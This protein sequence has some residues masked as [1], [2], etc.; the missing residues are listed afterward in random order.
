MVELYFMVLANTE[1]YLKHFFVILVVLSLFACPGCFSKNVKMGGKVTFSDDKSPLTV[2]TVVFE[3]DDYQARGAIKPDG[4]YTLGSLKETD[5]LPPG[6]YRV[7]IKG[8][9]I[10]DPTVDPN[11]RD[12][13]PAL[14]LLVAKFETGRTSGITVDVDA[15]TKRFDFSVDRN[16]KTKEKMDKAGK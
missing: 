7:Y 1:M 15:S 16:P 9:S 4:S 8:A 3:T 5:G 11:R 14:P 6:T 2:G 12:G 13:A 10:S